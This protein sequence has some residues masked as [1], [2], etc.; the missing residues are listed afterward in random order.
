MTPSD[1]RLIILDELR[2]FCIL[3]VVV[4]HGGFDLVNLYHLHLPMFASPVMNF[5]QAFFAGIFVM[6][7][8]ITCYFSRSNFKRGLITFLL[9][10]MLTFITLL[11]IPDMVIRFGILHLLGA[12][13]LTF[14]LFRPLLD[15]LSPFGSFLFFLLLFIFTYAVPNH[16]LGI[17]GWK[18]LPL[19]SLWYASPFLAF[20]GFPFP[21]FTSGDYFPL[22]PWMFLFLAGTSLGRQLTLTP[23]PH[24]MKISRFPLLAALGRHSLL[25]Y[26]LHQPLLILI[27]QILQKCFL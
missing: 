17:L 27:F 22:I 9:A 26:L 14:P 19:S 12:C 1:N 24:W 7:A 20:A 21:G 23:A 2:G 3:L 6:L 8:G 25:I 18:L 15:K 5:L 13:M 10:V 11:F 4:Y 16:A